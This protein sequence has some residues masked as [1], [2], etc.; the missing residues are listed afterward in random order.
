M[1]T[2][3][4]PTEPTVTV[5]SVNVPG[6][7]RQVNAAKYGA[8]KTALLRVLPRSGAGLTQEAMWDAVRPILPGRLF[9]GG[10]NAEWWAKCVQL[11][12]EAQGVVV[13]DKTAKPLRWRRAA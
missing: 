7:Q 10:A 3:R 9:P 6:Y 5:R 1:A 11:D 2:R 12:L 8:M 13:R 4:M